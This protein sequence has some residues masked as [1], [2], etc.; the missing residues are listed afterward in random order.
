M[1][2][3]KVETKCRMM[4]SLAIFLSLRVDGR[5]ESLPPG[6]TVGR[7]WASLVTLLDCS[8]LTCEQQR[9]GE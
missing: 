3:S 1:N 2:S 6:L 4:I 7:P 8:I 9:P 5:D